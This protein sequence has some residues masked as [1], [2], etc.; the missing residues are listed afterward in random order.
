MNDRVQ[1]S[2]SKSDAPVNHVLGSGAT[3]NKKKRGCPMAAR[4]GF[5]AVPGDG[6]KSRPP[7]VTRIQGPGLFDVEFVNTLPD[8][9]NAS[10]HEPTTLKKS[11]E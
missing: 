4:N 7:D 2:C 6:C 8:I 5:T 9:Y 11:P 1:R 3:L 10:F